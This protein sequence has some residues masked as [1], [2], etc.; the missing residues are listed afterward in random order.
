MG[1]KLH[2]STNVVK[3]FKLVGLCGDGV[4]SRVQADAV[5]WSLSCV[6]FALYFGL[7]SYWKINCKFPVDSRFGSEI[8]LHFAAFILPSPSTSCQALLQ[9]NIPTA[10]NAFSKSVCFLQI[11][12]CV[13]FFS[14]LLMIDLTALQII[15]TV[16]QITLSP[17]WNRGAFK[18]TIKTLFVISLNW[19]VT[20]YQI[21]YKTICGHFTTLI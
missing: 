3:P 12:S 11:D 4:S 7:L 16:F 6:D 1:W 2:S 8:Y 15:F 9:K 10:P 20:L 14:L 5:F 19:S 13:I 17:F 18:V 21:K